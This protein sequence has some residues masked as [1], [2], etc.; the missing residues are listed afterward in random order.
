[1]IK[2]DAILITSIG[3]TGTEFFAKFFADVVP[4]C[5]S[6]HEPDIIQFVGVESRFRQLIQQIRRV[7]LWRII[8]LKPLGKWSLVKLSDARFLGLIDHDHA[9]KKLYNQR[10]EFIQNMPGSIYVESNI[11]FYGLLD[12]ASSVFKNQRVVYIIR[13]GRDWVRSS[14]NWGEIY[15]KKGLRKVYAHVWPSAKDFSDDPLAEDWDTLSRFEKL[16][17]AWTRLNEYALNSLKQ[18]PSARLFQFEKIFVGQ[19]RYQYLDELLRFATTLPSINFEEIRKPTGWLERKIHQSSDN[20]P[21]WENWS[22]QQ[23]SQFKDICGPLMTKLG[24]EL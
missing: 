24:Y 5:T 13:D 7:G 8:F 12:V 18:N 1:M 16:C 21:G 11:G 9:A 10:A 2:K 19:E 23:K 17:W 22:H 20:F 14:I 6:L 15:G 3:R 4:N